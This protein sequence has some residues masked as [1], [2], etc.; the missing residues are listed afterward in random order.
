MD[1]LIQPLEGIDRPAVEGILKIRY[2]AFGHVFGL[3]FDR[4]CTGFENQP[5][6][7]MTVF[8][9]KPQSA[10]GMVQGRSQIKQHA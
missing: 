7:G 3:I 9:S 10:A 8:R 5:K 1:F 4:R 6:V 2:Y